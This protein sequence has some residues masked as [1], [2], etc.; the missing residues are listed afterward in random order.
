MFAILDVVERSCA[1]KL[2]R[3]LFADLFINCHSHP[4]VEHRPRENH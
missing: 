3:F 2:A 4:Q 1:A